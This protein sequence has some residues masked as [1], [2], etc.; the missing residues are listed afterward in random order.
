MINR[1]ILLREF[2][3]A[4][5][6]TA[7][8]LLALAVE[9]QTSAAIVVSQAWS[10]ATPPGAPVAGGYVTITNKSAQADRLAK[11]TTP[12]SP[13][14][15]IHEMSMAGGVM[16]MR[17]MPDGLTLAPGQTIVLKPGGLHLMFVDPKAPLKEGDIFSAT[18]RFEHAGDVPVTFKVGPVGA[19]TAP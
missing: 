14:A 12:V 10:R 2:I 1:P 19:Q 5:V 7:V 16:R 13:T 3:F 17:E 18:L 11:V 4:T 9:A 6:L 15:Q 8:A